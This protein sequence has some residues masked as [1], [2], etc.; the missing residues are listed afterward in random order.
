MVEEIDNSNPKSIRVEVEVKT[1]IRIRETIKTGTDKMTDLTAET[2]DNTDKTEV[3]FDTN[4]IIEEIILEEML[5]IMVD[6]IVE[7]NIETAIEMRVMIEAGTDL[8]KGCFPEIMTIIELEVQAIVDAGQ[9]PEL[10]QIGIE[11]IVISAGNKIISQETVD[12]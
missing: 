7:E 8:E 4:K 3:V 12:F 11:Y 1:E 5:E 10:A 2:E 6:K 9:D